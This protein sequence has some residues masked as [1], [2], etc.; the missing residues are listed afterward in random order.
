[1]TPDSEIAFIV[2]EHKIKIHAHDKYSSYGFLTEREIGD[3]FLG[4]FSREDTKNALDL[5]AKEG[6]LEVYYRKSCHKCHTDNYH[7]EID[8]EKKESLHDIVD[9]GMTCRNCDHKINVGNWHSEVDTLYTIP[10][11]LMENDNTHQEY[12]NGS[13]L[14]KIFRWMF[15]WVGKDE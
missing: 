10:Q 1:M 9:F 11:H 3:L 6:L 13:Y 14:Q 12:E 5:A 2:L 4:K 7:Q 8:N 15:G